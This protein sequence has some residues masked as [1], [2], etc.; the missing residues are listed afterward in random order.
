MIIVYEQELES[1]QV[2]KKELEK[3]VLVLRRKLKYYKTMV[4]DT[5]E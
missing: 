5:E 2:E 4:E 3:E 1:L